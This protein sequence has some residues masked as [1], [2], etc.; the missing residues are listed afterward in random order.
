MNILY[1]YAELMS[2]QTAIFMEYVNFYGA[3]VHTVHWDQGKLTP[4][5]PPIIEG[6][7]Y[8]RRSHYSG[9]ELEEL[10]E[11]INP[12]IVYVTAWQDKGYL[13]VVR[14]LRKKGIPVVAGFDDQWTGSTKQYIASLLGPYV[15]KRYFS[16]AWVA[17]PYQ[18]EYVRRLGFSNK[19]IIFNLL[20]GDT[21]LFSKGTRYLQEK[22]SNYPKTFLCVG[23]FRPIKGTD[24]LVKAFKLYRKDYGGKWDLICIGNGESRKLLE[25]IPRIRILDFLEQSELV[26]ITRES[27]VFI[28]PSRLDQWGVVVHEFA[29]AGLPLLLSKNVGARTTFL[30]DNF[31]GRS[32][33]SGSPDALAQGMHILSN[34]NVAELIVMG[35]NSHTLSQVISPATVAASF[36]SALN[37]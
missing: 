33:E 34:K 12:D 1:L 21:S 31:N 35:E 10:V 30:I 22:L 14:M 6:V 11:K 2:Y 23:N 27:G 15:L 28:L 36:L 18:Y 4:Y 25:N 16:H 24:I 7:T 3:K 37:S 20:S 8:Y 13:A 29:S 26:K 17:G 19:D 5:K 32:F 9:R